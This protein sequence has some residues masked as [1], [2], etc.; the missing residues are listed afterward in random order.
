[1]NRLTTALAASLLALAA[2]AHGAAAAA[3]NT[4]DHAAGAAA[5]DSHDHAGHP[6]AESAGHDAGPA[7]GNDADPGH[8]HEKGHG[9]DEAEAA[10]PGHDGDDDHA[11]AE[12]QGDHELVLSDSVRREFGLSLRRAEAGTLSVTRRVTGEVIYNPER[13]AHAVPRAPGVARSVAVRVGDRVEAGQTLAV[14]DSRELAEARSRYLAAVSRE[15]IARTNYRREAD[16]WERKVNSERDYLEAKQALAEARVERRLTEHQLH[17]LGLAEEEIRSL[18]ERNEAALTRYEMAAPID[19]VVVERHVV[20]GEV[21][22][23]DGDQPPFVIADLS[24]VWV[25]LTIYPK[26]LPSIRAGQAVTVRMAEGIPPARGRIDY[27]AP[28]LEEATRTATARVVLPNPEGR[29]K[30]GLFVTAEV[31][32]AE[33]RAGVVVPRNAVQTLEGRTVVFVEHEGRLEPRPVRLGANDADSVAVV[34][35]L[36]PGERYVA[37][38][39]FTLKAELAKESFGGHSH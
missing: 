7:E 19:G 22:R 17:A 10:S 1:M 4:D 35:G 30:P 32:V 23:A 29:W 3:A 11:H 6:E 34:A 8:E 18:P 20:P 36:E 12:A 15:D 16:L 37:E 33:D 2:L 28:A 27:V 13:Y 31:A 24:T 9:H 5:G 14:L 38:N 25:N 21:L 39:A 26:D